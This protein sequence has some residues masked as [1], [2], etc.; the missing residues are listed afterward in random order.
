MLFLA[1]RCRARIV[2]TERAQ[3][4]SLKVIPQILLVQGGR[5]TLEFSWKKSSQRDLTSQEREV[6]E[7]SSRPER[8]QNDSEASSS[9]QVEWSCA[10]STSTLIVPKALRLAD[11]YGMV[12]PI[13]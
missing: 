11:R 6:A 4:M 1:Y 3:G 10:H 5:Q 2:V 9:N 12:L 7:G 8:E 13:P